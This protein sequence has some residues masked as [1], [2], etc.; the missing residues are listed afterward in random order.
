[1]EIAPVAYSCK[2]IR[3]FNIA[4]LFVQKYISRSSLLAELIVSLGILS[5]RDEVATRNNEGSIYVL[6]IRWD[7]PDDSIC[8]RNFS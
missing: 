1:M 5:S 3:F 4:F 7:S 8:T 2:H 6:A